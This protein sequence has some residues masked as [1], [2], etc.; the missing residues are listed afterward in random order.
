M[1]EERQ[2][3]LDLKK[4]FIEKLK[5]LFPEVH[6]NGLSENL[7]KSTYTL[8]NVALP[9]DS[10]KAAL[11][12][13]HMDLKGIACSKG[14]ACQAGSNI[15]SH[16]LDEVVPKELKSHP[17]IRFSFSCFNTKEEIDYLLEVLAEFS[18]TSIA[19]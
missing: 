12:S 10:S 9:I 13:F 6:F 3:I 4:Y 7:E 11:L 14:S 19:S 18:T 15:G 1:E 16:V 2:Y 8:V 17:S 5:G